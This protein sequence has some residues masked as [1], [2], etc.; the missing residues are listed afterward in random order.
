MTD[1]G[2]GGGGGGYG[3]SNDKL[4]VHMRIMPC[5]EG[6]YGASNDKVWQNL[7]A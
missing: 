6:W 2:G 4:G 3:A 7:Y 5:G 1:V